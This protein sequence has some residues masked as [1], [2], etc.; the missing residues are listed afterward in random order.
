MDAEDSETLEGETQDLTAISPA[1]R[2]AF[3]GIE[4]ALDRLNRLAVAI[5]RSSNSSLVSRVKK[6]TRKRERDD[7][8]ERLVLTIVKWQFSDIYEPLAIQLAA[9]IS[10]RRERLLYQ[11]SHQRKLQTH[12]QRH[13]APTLSDTVSHEQ[14][15][16]ISRQQLPAAQEL[17]NQ[18]E[19]IAP[20]ETV[21]SNIDPV[22][23][24]QDYADNE[25]VVSSGSTVSSLWCNE[26]PYPNR[27]KPRDGAPL[28]IECS[29]CFR[30]LDPSK[31][32]KLNWWRYVQL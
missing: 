28:S 24:R 27:P 5:R 8:F 32:E 13:L 19:V 30:P 11:R 12:R 31:L 1:S 26:H 18:T 6:F 23:V 14:P 4:G 25:T 22:Y 10:Y 3:D 7:D 15:Q 17:S 2:Q 20:S 29:W 16:L 9:S 21:P